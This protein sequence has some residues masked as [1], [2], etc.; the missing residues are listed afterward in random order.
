MNMWLR[1]KVFQV[2]WSPLG[3]VPWYSTISKEQSE[4]NKI[5]PWSWANLNENNSDI[6]QKISKNTQDVARFST[7]FLQLPFSKSA[8]QRKL[9]INF[10]QKQLPSLIEEIPLV[11]RLGA[12]LQLDEAH[13]TSSYRW[14]FLH[15]AFPGRRIIGTYLPIKVFR[16]YNSQYSTFR[17]IWSLLV[18]EEK[19]NNWEGLLRTEVDAAWRPR[20]NR[21]FF[22]RTLTLKSLN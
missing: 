14:H 2:N 11:A 7:E 6:L 8:S 21:N 18:D 3:T 16:C 10:L 1:S 15:D 20:Y 4:W 12:Y 5:Y 9:F 17:D 22:K 13:H 19:T